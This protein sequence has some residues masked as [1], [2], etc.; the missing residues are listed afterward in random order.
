MRETINCRGLEIKELRT[1]LENVLNAIRYKQ[2]KEM[3]TV[4]TQTQT[5]QKKSVQIQ[6][7]EP[8]GN[9]QKTE[10]MKK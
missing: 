2:S 9:S 7:Y 10:N 5:E 6:T 8:N 3:V 4:S 1:E